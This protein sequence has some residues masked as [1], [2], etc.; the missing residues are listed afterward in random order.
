M[1]NQSL[2]EKY[3][4]KV[5]DESNIAGPGGAFGG[6]LQGG[7]GKGGSVGNSDWYAAGD[8]RIPTSIYGKVIRRPGIKKKKRRSSKKNK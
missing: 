5:L 7:Q 1:K 8:A 4:I 6:N 2:F 3:F